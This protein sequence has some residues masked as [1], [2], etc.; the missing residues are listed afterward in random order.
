MHKVL[1]LSKL[2]INCINNITLSD[3]H[4]HF[5][6]EIMRGATYNLL[7]I[8]LIILYFLHIYSFYIL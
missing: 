2:Y 5:E 8:T 7:S 3:D 6:S 1:L 4:K